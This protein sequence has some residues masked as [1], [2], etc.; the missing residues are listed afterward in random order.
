MFAAALTWPAPV[1]DKPSIV[2]LTADGNID[3]ISFT[4]QSNSF[5]NDVSKGRLTFEDIGTTSLPSYVYAEEK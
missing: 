4:T 5:Y 1:N 3:Y 2:K